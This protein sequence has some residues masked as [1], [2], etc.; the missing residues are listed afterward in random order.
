MD[1]CRRLISRG[2]LDGRDRDHNRQSGR[3]FAGAGGV[4]SRLSSGLL[5]ALSVAAGG[6][7]DRLRSPLQELGIDMG[8]ASSVL[9]LAA[10]F[11]E[12]I[13]PIPA[14]PKARPI[15]ARWR[16][17]LRRK[18][19]RRLSPPICPDYSPRRARTFATRWKARCAGPV[20]QAFP[21]LL[22]PPSQSQPRILS[23]PGDCRSHRPRPR[24]PSLTDHVAFRQALAQHCYEAALIVETFSSNGT[25]RRTGKEGSHRPKLAELPTSLSRSSARSCDGEPRM[26]ERLFY[27]GTA[28]PP[29]DERRATQLMLAGE[30]RNINRDFE[31]IASSSLAMSP[32]GLRDLLD[33]ATY[34]FVADRTARRG[35][36]TLPNLGSDWRRRLRFVIAVREPERWNTPHVNAMLQD[37]V[38][39]ASDDDYRFTSCGRLSPLFPS[40]LPLV[41]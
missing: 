24:L 16:S 10:A 34:V 25:R 29:R 5:A 37:L 21:R 41:S 26:S 31:D 35:G 1:R 23:K 8:A 22:R 7:F 28:P 30:R 4:R 27:C 2:R 11:Q 14:Q 36:P 15:S 13:A 17:S 6:A 38:G 39:F 20:R 9:S 32:I 12:A 40:R 33:I 19:L 18:H 3:E